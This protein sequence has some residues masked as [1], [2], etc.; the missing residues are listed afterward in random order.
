MHT[1]KSTSRLAVGLG[2]AAGALFSNTV[3]A[4]VLWDGD[5]SHGTGVFN[6]IQNE[7]QNGVVEVVSDSTYGKVFRMTCNNPTTNIKTRCEASGMKGFQPTNTGTYY[8]GWRHKWGP[9]PT[10]SSKWMVLEQIHLSGSASAGAPV[11][12]GLSAPGDGRIH[13][14]L[15]NETSVVTD[16]WNHSLPLNSWHSFVYYMKFSETVSNGWLELWFDG[17]HQTMQSGTTRQP[18]AMAHKDCSSYWKWGVYRSGGGGMIGT[19]VAYLGQPKAGTTFADVNPDGGSGGPTGTTVSFEGESLAFT[20]SGQTVTTQADSNA[21][22]GTVAYFNATGASQ[23][24]EFTTG[25]V[26]AG[27]YSLS[28][29]YKQ[30]ASRGQ[31]TVTVDG[32]QVGGTVD[33]YGTSVAYVNKTI[34]SITFASA[35]T[36]TIRLSVTGKNGSSG[37][38]VL[39]PDVLKFTA[40]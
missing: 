1:I 2:L 20:T 3:R 32:A 31:H 27:S 38:Y 8:F 37:G 30:N 34:G 9:L 12:L 29:Q 17:V 16:A 19:A 18:C 22:G 4:S 28:L 24:V 25:T 33:E 39:A 5:A 10:S 26:Q 35:G 21:S 23:Y 11:P 7:N 36:H 6:S 13:L 40:Q 15:Q 14:N